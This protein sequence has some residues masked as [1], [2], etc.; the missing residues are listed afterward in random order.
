MMP[1]VKA[2]YDGSV[3][4]PTVPVEVPKGTE[5]EVIVP[6]RNPTE[7]ENREWQELLRQVRDTSPAWPP[8]KLTP[9]QQA[10]WEE[11]ERQIQASESPFPSVEDYLRYTRRYP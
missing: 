8:G 6:P 2:T 1:V 10:E 9:D 3:F 11:I 4:V 7:H 5:V